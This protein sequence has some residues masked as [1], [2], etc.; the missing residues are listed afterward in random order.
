[1]IAAAATVLVAVALW[2]M[3]DSH[4]TARRLDALRANCF[5]INER[6]HLVRYWEA[7]A[8]RRAKAESN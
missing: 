6:G 4:R 2:A 5:I 7:S 3:V 1:M 8:E